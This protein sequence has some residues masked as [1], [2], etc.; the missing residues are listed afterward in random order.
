[1]TLALSGWKPAQ[2]NIRLFIVLNLSTGPLL[3][4]S[5]MAAPGVF[6]A[7]NATGEAAQLRAWGFILFSTATLPLGRT[8]DDIRCVGG[9]GCF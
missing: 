3:Q 7:A 1:M 2:P 6:I 4:V 9:N 8:Y 5:F